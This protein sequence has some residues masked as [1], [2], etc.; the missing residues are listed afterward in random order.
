MSDR[1]S[2]QV[3]SGMAVGS[4]CQL[5]RFCWSGRE[6]RAENDKVVGLHAEKGE[7]Y[8]T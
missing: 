2:T 8:G 1:A 4:S 5:E 7:H 6:K 3:S